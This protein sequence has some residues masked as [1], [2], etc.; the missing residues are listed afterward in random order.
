MIPDDVIAEIRTR[1]DIVA[2]IGTHVQ[3]KKAGRNWKGLCPFHGERTPSFNVSPDKGYFYCFGCQKKGD[4]FTFVMEYEGKSFAEAAEQLA[5]RAGVVIPVVEESPALRRA[6]GERAQ[7]LEVNKLATQF[8][9]ETLAHPERGAAGRAYLEKRGVSAAITDRFQLGYAPADWHLLAEFLKG[10][11]IDPEIAIKVG[12]IARQVRAGGYYDRFRDRLVCPVVMPGGEV[13]G[14]SAR[15]VGEQVT[16]D[17]SPVA[18]YINSPESAVYKK[19]R[20]LFGLAQARESFGAKKRAVVVEGNFDVITLH[21]AGFTEVVAPLGTALTPEQIDTLRRLADEVVLCYDGDRA[22]R[23]ATRSALELMVLADIPV[24]IVALPD[25]EDP[26]SL[27]ASGGA[28]RLTQLIER[29]QGGVEYFAFEVWGRARDSADARSRALEDAV[30]LV[31]KVANQTKRDLI[32][33][34]LASA[35]SLP[36]GKVQEALDR[37]LRQSSRESARPG[38]DARGPRSGGSAQGSGPHHAPRGTERPSDRD[39]DDPRFSGGHGGGRDPR[40]P[41]SAMEPGRGPTRVSDGDAPRRGPPPT[42]EVEVLALLADHPNL[43]PTADSLGVFSLLTDA[44][45][46]DMYSA[47]REGQP[48]TELAPA[49]LPPL[50]AELVLSAK[51]VAETDPHVR[52]TVMTSGLKRR[53][54]HERLKQLHARM[55]EAQR[56]GDRDLARSLFAEIVST[57]KQVD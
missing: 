10:K 55:T 26:D 34:T 29:A 4:A 37:A 36:P 9:R 53:A 32:T 18:K 33:G 45:L 14:F 39:T 47:S 24:R 8:F 35:M 23:T 54:E 13:A 48:F 30:R 46:R 16:K 5:A 50:H 56:H 19:S 6:R 12:L 44:R 51:Y 43:I 57:R 1:V 22:G 17:G 2:V 27:V 28:D 42:E 38:P 25:G 7:M 11:R 49:H 52:L 41:R 31:A 40:D 20:L 15:V 21:Q 3:L